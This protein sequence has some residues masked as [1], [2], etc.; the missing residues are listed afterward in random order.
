MQVIQRKACIVFLVMQLA[1][2][3]LIPPDYAPAPATS[4]ARAMAGPCAEARIA[5]AP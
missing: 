1:A 4:G 5:D 3:S 2:Q